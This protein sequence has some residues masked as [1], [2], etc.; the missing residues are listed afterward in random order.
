[1]SGIV[2]LIALLD[3]KGLRILSS[4]CKTDVH[5]VKYE[6]V[7]QEIWNLSAISQTR[8]PKRKRIRVANNWSTSVNDPSCS[9]PC[10][11]ACLVWLP[12]PD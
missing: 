8:S 2:L 4:R 3:K 9:D 12:L 11:S 10:P 5:V 1:M 7:A 6:T